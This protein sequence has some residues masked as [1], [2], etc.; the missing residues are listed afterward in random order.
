MYCAIASSK[1]CI[2]RIR[3]D[4][5]ALSLPLMIRACPCYAGLA[6]SRS[7]SRAVVA[8]S[9]RGGNVYDRLHSIAKQQELRKEQKRHIRCAD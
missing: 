6:G 1:H 8:T 3:A 5:A 4:V 2:Y 9:K 7:G